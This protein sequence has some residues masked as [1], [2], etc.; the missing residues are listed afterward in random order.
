M[1]DE[2]IVEAKEAGRPTWAVVAY[3]AEKRVEAQ[4]LRLQENLAKAERTKRD[5]LEAAGGVKRAAG[6]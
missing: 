6:G 5:A 4:R 1:P 2:A 3:P